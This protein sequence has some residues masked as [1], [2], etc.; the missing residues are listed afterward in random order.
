MLD[1]SGTTENVPLAE[2]PPLEAGLCVKATRNSASKGPPVTPKPFANVPG[3]HNPSTRMFTKPGL[4]I[5]SVIDVLVKVPKT[6]LLRAK[7]SLMV[8]GITNVNDPKFR[9]GMPAKTPV[10]LFVETKPPSMNVEAVLMF[11]VLEPSAVGVPMSA[12]AWVPNPEISARARPR[13][14]CETTCPRHTAA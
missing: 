7:T 3:D 12:K 8:R 6:G 4:L 10:L 1:G 11:P 9:M 2:I 14:D 5:G 13:V